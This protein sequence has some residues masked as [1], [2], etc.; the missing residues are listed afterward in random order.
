MWS[1]VHLKMSYRCHN[2]TSQPDYCYCCQI[3]KWQES[4][5]LQKISNDTSNIVHFV[6]IQI[7]YRKNWLIP[8][9]IGHTVKTPIRLVGC[10]GWSESSLGVQVILLVL[11]C[12]GLLFNDYIKCPCWSEV[13]ACLFRSQIPSS[14]SSTHKVLGTPK[15]WWNH[16]CWKRHKTIE[17]TASSFWFSIR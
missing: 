12:G 8:S 15:Q 4:L 7:L 2:H 11:S 17:S 14:K 16:T 9:P 1:N 10:P 6:S 5:I 3:N 13:I